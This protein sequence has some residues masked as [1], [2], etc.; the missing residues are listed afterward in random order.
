VNRQGKLRRGLPWLGVV[1]ALAA[2]GLAKGA[3]AQ[4][5]AQAQAEDLLAVY[6]QAR[7]ADPV[8]AGADAQRG[9]QHEL[10]VQ[11]RAALLPQ[12]QLSASDAR[13]QPGGGNGTQIGSSL[14][15]TVFDL[16]RLRS[17]EAER[18]QATAQDAL[19]QAAEQAL[20]GRVAR[21]YF[22]VLLA[23]VGLSAAQANEDTY[24]LQV[25]QAQARYAAGLA[26]QVDVEQARTYHALSRGS[27]VQARQALAD[28]RQALAQITGREPAALKPL[29]ADLPA[30]PP[31]PA[32][33]AAWVEQ[34]LRANPAL[35]AQQLSLD[36]SQQRV[37]AARAAHWPTLSAGI[38]SQRW[39]GVAAQ[40]NG[41]SSTQVALRLSVPLF[42]GGATESQVRQA[43][44][45]RDGARDALEA[46]RRALVR[47]TQAQVQ[48]VLAGVALMD[49]ARAA[50]TAADR[51]LESTRAGQTLGTRTMT[52]LLLAIQTQTSAR[53]ALDQ[54][55]H[56]YVLARL[57]LLQAAGALGEA[58]L[59]AVNPWLQ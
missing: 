2:L 45:Q 34:A 1:L 51:A 38:D 47:E 33:P 50:V 54:A 7:A 11:A 35:R 12:W 37:A 30:L 18:T 22:G 15:Q 5:Q 13:T 39:G 44:W 32:D 14:S 36:A 4:A 10:A 6:A 27:T 55:R 21:A 49:S 17:W 20:C 19:V 53:N 59:A 29:A 43:A 23:Q 28:A 25:A 31:Q 56:G 3:D 24:A 46:A 57:L 52:D 9:V 48:A 8:L 16:G 42:A 58:E 40:A 26:A 41:R